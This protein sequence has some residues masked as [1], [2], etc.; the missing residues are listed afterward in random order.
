M[1]SAEYWDEMSPDSDHKLFLH[2]TLIESGLHIFVLSTIYIQF[3]STYYVD[4]S[5]D[6]CM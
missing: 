2:N 6:L 3:I 5:M 4:L 1:P